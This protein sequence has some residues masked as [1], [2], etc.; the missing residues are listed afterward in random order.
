MSAFQKL[1]SPRGIAVV[2]AQPDPTRGGGQPLRALQAYGY[3][4]GIY[5]V[6][7]SHREVNGLRCFRS[8]LDIDGPCDVAVI[9]IPPRA[10]IEAVR[11]CGR[12]GIAFVVMYSGAFR[13]PATDGRMLEDD[14]R[15]AA[16]EAGVRI[17][18]P[19]CLGVVNV[20]ENVY[21]SFGSMSR[22]PKLR[23]GCVSL[24]SQSGG[25]GYSMVLRCLRDGAGF[26]Y[27]VSTGNE[28]DVTTPELID[29][30]LDDPGTRVVIAYI[31]GVTDGRALLAAGRKAVGMGK[32]ILLWKAGNSEEGRRAAASHTGNMTGSYDIYHVALKQSGI[33]EVCGFEELSELVKAFSSGRRPAGRRVALVSASGG[34]AAV[35]SDCAAPYGLSMPRPGAA[36]MSALEKLELDIGDSI[37][38]M[39]CAPG[40]LNDA[41]AEKFTR[42]IDLILGDP[43]I[44]QLCM[45]LMTVLGK[46][47]LNGA[48][49]LAA[50]AA[51]HGKPV[52]VFSSVP[53]DTASEAFDV[54]DAAHIPVFTS[55]T[56]VARAAAA[57]AE[58]AA[59]REKPPSAADVFQ[60]AAPWVLPTARGALNEKDSKALLTS[61]GVRVSRDVMLAP[62]GEQSAIVS[63]VAGLSAPFAVKVV[64]QDIPHKSEVGGVRLNVELSSLQTASRDVL[65]AARAAA[66]HARIEGVMVSEM[67][68]DG[69]EALIGVVNDPTFGPVVAF[70]LGGIFA[71]VLKDVAYRVAP[72]DRDAANGM[73]S[74]LRGRAIFEGL[75]GKPALDVEA[76]A[77]TLVAISQLAWLARDRI[78][79]IDINPLMVR[80]RGGGVVA[81]DALVVLK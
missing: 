77:D 40:F 3:S 61:C 53:R 68:T 26:R 9:A 25:F 76:V 34:A 36:T 14:L 60:P 51:R 2:G 75:R 29:A 15:A 16:A 55:P 70:G 39:D 32:A 13:V 41:E 58:F 37:N 27:L 71:E 8:I 4:G 49:A 12:K 33:M 59:Y 11:A 56:N 52:L 48:R 5:P 24:V 20:S 23:S 46:Q 81:V 42:A 63:L 65:E 69:F 67:I 17:I 66:P 79:E 19:N 72:F 78:A 80:P 7:P 45:M 31:E 30:Y 54:L 18:G 44:D 47:A 50:A 22:E 21:A 64:S 74:E 1:F 38:P 10:A 43:S 57:L 73:L 35:F 62:E 6:H 28:S